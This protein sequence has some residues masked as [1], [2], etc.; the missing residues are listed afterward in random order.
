M[1]FGLILISCGAFFMELSTSVGKYEIKKRKESMYAMGFLS[2]ISSWA[3]FGVTMAVHR[4]IGFSL[5]SL[6]SFLLRAALEIFQMYV[7][8]KAIAMASRSTYA[9]IHV[10]TIPIL[11]AIDL[12]LINA[13]IGGWQIIGM[14][15]IVLALFVLTM[16]HGID[17]KG[18]IFV[19]LSTVNGAATLTLF[20]YNITNFNT[21]EGEQF[22]IISIILCY[23]AISAWKCCGEKPWRLLR[24]PVFIAQS[25]SY[26]AGVVLD[27]FA[28]LFAPASVITVIKRALSVLWSVLAGHFV[29]KEKSFIIKLVCFFLTALGIFL[30]VRF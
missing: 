22:F 5:A 26:G 1:L 13:P 7:S 3:F 15:A 20:K 12:F 11:L 24:K 19:I 27:S 30:I 4:E 25:A 23:L 6:P 17:K 2:L 21:V 14:T 18:L 9:F 8:L 29:F 28:Y 16:N 10:G